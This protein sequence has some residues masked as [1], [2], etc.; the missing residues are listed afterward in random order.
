MSWHGSA[1]DRTLP[2]VAETPVMLGVK[3][4]VLPIEP[5]LC[6]D[7]QMAGILHAREALVAPC[8]RR[9]GFDWPAS[10]PR[11]SE[12]TGTGTGTGMKN[13]ANISRRYG[14]TDLAA[15][16]R[17]GYHFASDARQKPTK[18]TSA[19]QPHPDAL[20]VLTGRTDEG[21]PAPTRHH[22]RTVPQAGCQGQATAR[23]SG[24][25][26]RLG[27]GQ[28]VGEINIVSYQRSQTDPRVKSVFRAW[29][30]CVSRAVAGPDSRG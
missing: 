28:L 15:A 21:D 19:R 10:G 4:L 11:L 12:S 1:A 5:Y 8:M 16:A 29:S 17:Y 7:R 14:I 13:A 27:N 3:S 26:Q 20:A 25:P 24:D 30:A 9:F 23:L 2:P 6:T 22:G 18:D